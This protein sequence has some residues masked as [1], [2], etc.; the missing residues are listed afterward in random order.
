MTLGDKLPRNL[1]YLYVPH[2]HLQCF[3]HGAGADAGLNKI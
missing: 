3:E 1:L 2:L